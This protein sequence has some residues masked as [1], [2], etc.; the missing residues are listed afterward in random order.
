M[1]KPDLILGDFICE[2]QA[3]KD[4]RKELHVAVNMLNS[5][6]A[7]DHHGTLEKD[8]SHSVQVLK[9]KLKLLDTEAK[10]LGRKVFELKDQP[11]ESRKQ[12]L[13][14][15]ADEVA[16][17]KQKLCSSEKVIHKLLHGL[18]RSL[19]KSFVINFLNEDIKKFK[20]ELQNIC[21]QKV[22]EVKRS[23]EEY[24]F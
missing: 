6:I 5:E 21:T 24:D 19:D 3:V 23:K 12:R 2:Y 22:I 17:I 14:S 9:S 1:E 10:E 20:R 7:E 11:G 8:L 18:D 16:E 13:S 15:W 4:R